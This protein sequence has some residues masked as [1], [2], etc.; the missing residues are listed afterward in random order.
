M[1]K[2]WDAAKT[3]LNAFKNGTAFNIHMRE[4]VLSMLLHQ[5]KRLPGWMQ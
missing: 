5:G 2:I 1:G 3:V 4:N